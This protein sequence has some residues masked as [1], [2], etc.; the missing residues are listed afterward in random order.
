MKI[1]Q[2]LS[3]ADPEPNHRAAQNR[4]QSGTGRWLTGGKAYGD[5][6]NAEGSFLWLY[7]MRMLLAHLS[8]NFISEF[9][10]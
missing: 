3:T 8:S 10:G 1:V 2:W 6:F 4:R 9:H 7:G 5:W